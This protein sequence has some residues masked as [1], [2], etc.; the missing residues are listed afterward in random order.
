MPVNPT[1]TPFDA[2][3]VAATPSTPDPPKVENTAYSAFVRRIL[4]AHARRV[5]DGD[6][7][8]LAEMVALRD[9]LDRGIAEAVTGLRSDPWNY[10]WAEVARPLGT[11]RQAAQQRYGR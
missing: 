2:E 9:E 1:L 10:S 11:T 8:G 7:E 3:S 4:R 5:A 6:V